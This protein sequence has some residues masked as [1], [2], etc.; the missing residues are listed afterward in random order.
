MTTRR[1]LIVALGAGALATPISSW[2]QQQ[3]KVTRIRFLGSETA[4]GYA[5]H[6]EALRAGLRKYGYVEGKNIACCAWRKRIRSAARF[7]RSTAKQSL[8]GRFLG[9]ICPA[10][11]FDSTI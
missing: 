11:N 5:T 1:E 7:L 2:A 8:A 6:I 4:S 9:T 3:N 10:G